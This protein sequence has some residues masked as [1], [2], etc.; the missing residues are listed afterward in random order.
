MIWWKP[1]DE[2]RSRYKPWALSLPD[3]FELRG[4]ASKL[5]SK[6]FN[7]FFHDYTAANDRDNKRW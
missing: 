1:A 7:A 3:T 6:H 5:V 2:Y 4:M